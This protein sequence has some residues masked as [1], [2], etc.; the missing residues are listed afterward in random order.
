[1]MRKFVAA[2]AFTAV[3]GLGAGLSGPAAAQEQIAAC[4]WD[5]MPADARG[6]VAAAPTEDEAFTAVVGMTQQVGEDG[7]AQMLEACGVKTVPQS[8]LAGQMFALHGRRVWS[9]ARLAHRWTP[10]Q[11]D[12]AFRM[13]TPQDL[14]AMATLGDNLA[15]D[16]PLT[17]ADE[18]AMQRF[19][20]PLVK[21]SKLDSDI[22]ETEANQM[23]TYLTARAQLLRAAGEYGRLPK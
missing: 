20:V 1:M 7:I 3:L 15:G 8:R 6:R 5:R 19:V 12:A 4:V 16:A 18:A 17:P 13:L 10:P 23:I 22:N 9:E 14:A 21:T 2:L 11:L